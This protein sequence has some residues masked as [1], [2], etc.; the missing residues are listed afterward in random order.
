V[1]FLKVT[2]FYNSY[3]MERFIL[4]FRGSGPKPLQDVEKIYSVQSIHVLDD[5]SPRMLLVE[6]PRAALT[7]VISSM[8][9][10]IMSAEI[11][12]QVPDPRP[13]PR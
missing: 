12:F 3:Y 5:S 1:L 11:G 7:K 2:D 4:R 9:D 10:W 13:K 6:A 8:Q